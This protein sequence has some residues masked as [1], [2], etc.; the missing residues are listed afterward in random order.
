[1]NDVVADDQVELVEATV[2]ASAFASCFKFPIQWTVTVTQIQLSLSISTAMLTINSIEV[3]Y[4]T[5]GV[6]K[7]FKCNLL[8]AVHSIESANKQLTCEAYYQKILIKLYII[9]RNSDRSSIR[10]KGEESSTTAA[11]QS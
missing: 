11:A 1:V 5:G 2:V 3:Q 10:V 9:S 6:P 4:I 7:L 8:R